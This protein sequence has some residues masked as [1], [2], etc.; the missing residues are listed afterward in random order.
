MARQRHCLPQSETY[1]DVETGGQQL[2]EA[3]MKDDYNVDISNGDE[4]QALSPGSNKYRIL[5]TSSA[6]EKML[7]SGLA[8]NIKPVIDSSSY[9]VFPFDNRWSIDEFGPL[10]IPKKGAVLTLTGENYPLYERAIRTYE[11]NVLEIKEGKIYINGQQTNQYTFK[12]DYFWMMGDNRHGSQDSRYWGFVPEDHIV[13]QAS[14]IWMSYD[15][16]IRWSR[17][18]SKIK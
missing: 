18:F 12:M 6:K 3:A 10:W 9:K 13:G 5:L 4:I 15:K 17:L 16:G 14:L 7:K 1:Y 2:D 11:K 8:K